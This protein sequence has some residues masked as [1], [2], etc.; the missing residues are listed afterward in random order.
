[1]GLLVGT[2]TTRSRVQG[3]PIR[4][5]KEDA[6]TQIEMTEIG[7]YDYARQLFEAHGPKAIAEAAQKACVFERQG[8]SEQAETWRHI[9]DALKLM[10]GP[11]LS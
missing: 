4:G 9:E 7:I 10:R 5:E 3:A 8:D 1:M 11:H 6:M 2:N